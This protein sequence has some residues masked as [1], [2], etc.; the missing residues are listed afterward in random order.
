MVEE[1]I[2]IPGERYHIVITSESEDA[3]VC[4]F[5]N[6]TSWDKLDEKTRKQIKGEIKDWGKWR[7]YKKLKKDLEN[8]D[9]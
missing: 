8:K 1:K 5:R 9:G 2:E 4:V 6:N 7:I 3:L